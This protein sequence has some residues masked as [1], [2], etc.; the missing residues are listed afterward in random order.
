MSAIPCHATVTVE[1]S[2]SKTVLR[3]NEKATMQITVRSDGNDELN[4]PTMPEVNGLTISYR[5]SSNK[6]NWSMINGRTSIERAVIHELDVIAL[7]PGK[8]ALK[9]IKVK[10]DSGFVAAKPV[11]ISVL[12]ESAPAPTATPQ[13]APSVDNKQWPFYL[14]QINKQEAYVGEEVILTYYLLVPRE[15]ERS[16]QIDKIIEKQGAMQSFWVEKQDIGKDLEKE[17]VKI[18]NHFFA[19]FTINRYILYPLKPGKI[20]IDPLEVQG[21]RAVSM[22]LSVF[23][24]QESFSKFSNE[25]SLNVKPLPEEGKPDNFEGAVGRFQLNDKVDSTEIE[26]GDPVT[27]TIT[28]EGFGNLRNAPSPKLPD[29]SNF[30]Q[31]DPTNSEDITVSKDGVSGRVEYTHVLIPHDLNANEIG[32]VRYSYFDPQEAKYVS[33]ETPP[34]ALNIKAALGGNRGAFTSGSPRRIPTRIGDDF[35]F[36]N[37]SLLALA[38]IDLGVHRRVTLWLFALLPLLL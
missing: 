27:L 11:T 19:K 4:N 5:S 7:A 31:F 18:D 10:T 35:R 26:E 13:P 21:R 36:I 1:V 15:Y 38:Y 12:D 37:T 24:R 29:L 14:G 6:T 28:L 8:Y 16:I 9:D 30:D 2:L 22:G 23:R 34:I 3:I 33:L 17:Y 32:P 25:V 20:D